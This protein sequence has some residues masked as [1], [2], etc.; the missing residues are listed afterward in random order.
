MKNNK[1][2][3]TTNISMEIYPEKKLEL[4][5]RKWNENTLK[6]SRKSMD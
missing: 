2:F 6:V 3:N 1:N 4:K 5:R